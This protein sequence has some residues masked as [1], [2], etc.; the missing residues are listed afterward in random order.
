MRL[1]SFR[2]GFFL[3]LWVVALRAVQPVPL[4]RAVPLAMSVGFAASQRSCLG[5]F[6]PVEG[7]S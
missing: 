1:L 4:L 5:S 2:S 7:A 3:C 6:I